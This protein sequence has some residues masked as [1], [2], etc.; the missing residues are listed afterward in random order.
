MGSYLLLKQGHLKQ[1][2]Q[3]HVH[4]HAFEKLEGGRLHYLSAQPIPVIRHLYSKEVPPKAL[5]QTSSP[6]SKMHFCFN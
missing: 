2:S 4:L 5:F 3:V 1:V 6:K